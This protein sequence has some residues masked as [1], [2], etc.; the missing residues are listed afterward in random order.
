MK[1]H[2]VDLVPVDLILEILFLVVLVADDQQF[3]IG[4]RHA[5]KRI[6]RIQR[7]EYPAA[8]IRRS[9]DAGVQFGKLRGQFPQFTPDWHSF[10]VETEPF[11]VDRGDAVL[12]AL[13]QLHQQL[14]VVV[15]RAL[16]AAQS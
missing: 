7:R 5:V 6:V 11:I 1:D 13:L 4:A 3:D 15:H 8:A 12:D 2:A 14:L 10:P 9:E 16:L